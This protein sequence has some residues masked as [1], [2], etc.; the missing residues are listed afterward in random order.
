MSKSG[1]DRTAHHP[2]QLSFLDGSAA[3]V[4][5]QFS[6][7]PTIIRTA[8]VQGIKGCPLSRYQIA[9]RISELMGRDLSKDML[10]KY[11]A[12]SA[13]GY[14]FPAELIPAFCHVTHSTEL[15]EL[16]ARSMGGLFAGPSERREVEI[17]RLRME[18]ASLEQ[19]IKEL[20][21]KDR[22]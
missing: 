19:R 1:K 10:D 17:A 20:E 21:R 8:L 16:V 22:Q 6:D 18:K 15:I 12:D 3:I 11:T 5:G 2:G 14:R 7:I 4:E 13:E 9:A